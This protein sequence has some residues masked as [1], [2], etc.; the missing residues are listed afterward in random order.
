MSLLTAFFGYLTIVDFV[1][2]V[3]ISYSIYKA[4]LNKEN[5]AKN[6]Y[7]LALLISVLSLA[8]PLMITLS[9][10]ITLK[11]TNKE[12]SSIKR[13]QQSCLRKAL[14]LLL[15]TFVG[16]LMMIPL[17]LIDSLIKIG[18]VF[19]SLFGCFVKGKQPVKDMLKKI[20]ENLY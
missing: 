11:F 2:D 8:S 12:F 13:S 15:L 20:K 3:L 5:A 6:D 18:S 7:L 9:G 4:N 1:K 14:N 10:I 19:D 17:E 16:I